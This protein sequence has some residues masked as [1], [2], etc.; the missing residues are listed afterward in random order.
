MSTSKNRLRYGPNKYAALNLLV[1]R[2][3]R[4]SQSNRVPYKYVTLGGTELLDVMIFHWIDSQMLSSVLS[5][6]VN[7]ERCKLAQKAEE[8][9][10]QQGLDIT[11][12]EDDIF[13]YRRS[14][15]QPHIFFLDLEG[16]CK[17]TPFVRGF[18]EWLEFEVLEPGDF[19]MITSYLGRNPGWRRTLEQ[20]DAEF[21]LLRIRTFKEQKNLY[22]VAH[23]LFVLY[24]ALSE[25]GLNQDIFLNCLGY[26]KYRD[27]STM[28]LHGIV[29]SEGQTRFT[30]LIRNF[31]VFDMTRRDW[32]HVTFDRTLPAG[33][34]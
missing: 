8:R 28:G 34:S 20:F 5:F 2:W 16:V 32:E 26:V 15:E 1:A 18:R 22:R 6:E 17:P 14:V 3:L 10:R 21:R 31:P 13:E 7:S 4:L 30:D 27:T 23:P 29:I 9:I 11:I 25:S 24:Q 12:N 19:L 33:C